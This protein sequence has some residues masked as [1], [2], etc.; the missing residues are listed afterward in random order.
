MA[1]DVNLA[2]V[3]ELAVVPGLNARI[4]EKIVE[5]RAESSFANLADLRKRLKLT[6]AAVKKIGDS[7]HIE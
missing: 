7:L 2:S 4:A 3:D 1:P 6:D 5:A